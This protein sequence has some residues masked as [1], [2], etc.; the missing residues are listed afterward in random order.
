VDIEVV[1][2]TVP[3]AI[4]N[5]QIFQISV[6]VK[7]NGKDPVGPFP[8]RFSVPL[9]TTR[10]RPVTVVV[11]GVL[12]GKEIQVPGLAAGQ[13]TTISATGSF[14]WVNIHNTWSI[15]ASAD[16][17]ETILETNKENNVAVS[18]MFTVSR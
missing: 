13:T 3:G 18:G 5:G 6:V 14:S 11:D 8:I 12:G 4:N 17:D 2:V 1:R 15:T 10:I 16:P 9:G 7:N